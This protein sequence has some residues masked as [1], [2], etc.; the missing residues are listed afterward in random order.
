MIKFKLM[1]VRQA[2]AV[3]KGTNETSIMCMR[4]DLYEKQR[5]TTPEH[6]K[7]Y[8]QSYRTQPGKIIVHHG[9]HDDT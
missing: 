6:I 4:P 3:P 1:F 8:R 5:E 2:G 7:K 9:L